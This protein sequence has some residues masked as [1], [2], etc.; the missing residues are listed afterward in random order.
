MLPT[1]P[2]YWEEDED[3][4][5]AEEGEEDGN[6]D[7]GDGDGSEVEEDPAADLTNLLPLSIRLMYWEGLTLPSPLGLGAFGKSCKTRY[8]SLEVIFLDYPAEWL[9][10]ALPGRC[11]KASVREAMAGTGVEVRFRD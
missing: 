1:V 2:D 7:D 3:E 6:G 5:E 11:Y 4:D 10:V 8:P 9:R